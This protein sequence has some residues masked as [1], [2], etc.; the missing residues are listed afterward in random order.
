MYYLCFSF[1]PSNTKEIFEE[2]KETNSL[3]AQR[4]NR[5]IAAGV[6]LK[7]FK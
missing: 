4:F 7:E 2:W 3:T 6:E 1:A 5:N